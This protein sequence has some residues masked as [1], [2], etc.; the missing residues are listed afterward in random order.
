VGSGRALAADDQPVQRPASSQR[1]TGPA[2]RKRKRDPK[3]ALYQD[4]LGAY[5]KLK[6]GHRAYWEAEPKSFQA[7]IKKAHS[8][9]FRLKPGP[10][11]DPRIAQAARERVRGAPWKVLYRKNIDHPEE[12]PRLTQELARPGFQKKVN[13]FIRRHPRLQRESLERTPACK[14]TP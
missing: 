1:K 3:K 13:S 9:V 4:A 11:P 12:M 7:T 6:R 8:R 10:K 5:R 14:S 2:K